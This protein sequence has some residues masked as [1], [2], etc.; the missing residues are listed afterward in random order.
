MKAEDFEENR[1]GRAV[2]A[3]CKHFWYETKSS[4]KDSSIR[5]P[6]GKKF[7]CA[8]IEPRSEID[9]DVRV[10]DRDVRLDVYG[11]DLAWW[12]PDWCDHWTFYGEGWVKR[13][14]AQAIRKARSEAKAK[15]RQLSRIKE[16]ER[17][18]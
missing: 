18:R 6:T 17:C 5:V 2:C 3:N 9:D 14:F 13:E 16:N 1:W 11:H 12:K 10:G 8:Y 4:E 15:L 7:C